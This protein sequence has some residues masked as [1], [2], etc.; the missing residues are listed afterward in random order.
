MSKFEVGKFYSIQVAPNCGIAKTIPACCVRIT[1]TT[2]SFEYMVNRD[3]ILTKDTV[4]RSKKLFGNHEVAYEPDVWSRVRPTYADETREK[5][6][7]W[8][9]ESRSATQ[10]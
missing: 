4:R 2:V 5:P 9:G 10:L 8:G 1:K 3:G 7:Q 6:K